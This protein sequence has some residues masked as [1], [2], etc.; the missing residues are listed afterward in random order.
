MGSALI[1][2]IHQHPTFF[3]PPL[4]F[5]NYIGLILLLLAGVYT[6][7][8]PRLQNVV[9]FGYVQIIIDTLLITGIIFVTGSFSSIFSFLYLVVIIYASMVLS[10]TGGMF[11]AFCC[12]VQYGVLIA[13]EFQGVIYPVGI[14]AGFIFKNYNWTFI[15]FAVDY[16]GGLLWRG[17]FKRLSFRAGATGQ[18]GLWAM[19]EQVRRWR[20]SR[21]S[22]RWHPGW[23][24][25]LRIP[26]FLVRFHSQFLREDLA[27]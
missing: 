7:V 19:E 1:I 14:E 25:K 2:G 17:V 18:K 9:W 10:R 11:I 3:S 16:G 8:L 21:L 12:C 23:P 22:A 26:C 13:L 4:I 27:L 6:A 20:N 24:M 15:L 5:I